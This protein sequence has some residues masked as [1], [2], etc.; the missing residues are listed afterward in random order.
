MFDLGQRKTK[1]LLAVHGWAGI[2]FGIL[3]YAVVLTGTIAV[4]A[5]EIGHWSMGVSEGPSVDHR[6]IDAHVRKAVNSIDPRFRHDVSI[7]PGHGGHL[8]VWAHT[9]EKRPNGQSGDIGVL[10]E[11]DPETGHEIARREGWSTEVFRDAASAL[12]RFLIDV[13]VRLHLPNPWGLLLTGVLGLAMMAA[14]VSGFLMH[15]NLIRDS[16]TL[17]RHKKTL[18][19]ARD[20]HSVAGTWGLAFAFLLALTGAFFS[21]ALSIGLPLMTLVAFGG[22]QAKLRATLVGAP[23]VEDARPAGVADLDAMIRDAKVRVGGSVNRVSI[24]DYGRED[25]KVTIGLDPHPG[26]L[27]PA[28]LVYGAPDGAFVKRKARIG[29]E[30][31]F[32]STLFSTIGPL[33]FGNFGGV[34]SKL[35]W[36]AL[37]FA[38]CFM[39]ATGMSL[40]LRRR[41][42]DVRWRM[43]ACVNATVIFGLPIALAASAF[44]FFLSYPTEAALTTTPLAFLAAAL[45][46][47]VYACFI[48]PRVGAQALE[49]HL[50]LGL[51]VTLLA[52]PIVRIATGG[53]LWTNAFAAGAYEAFVIDLALILGGAFCIRSARQRGLSKAATA[54]DARPIEGSERP[55]MGAAE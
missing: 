47:I 26:T 51:G 14:A 7:F 49:A 44:G 4:F 46:V 37:G 19:A 12:E 18:V 21:F 3:L 17:R 9:H 34:I 8:R 35:V 22:D 27:E 31:S 55:Q 48:S 25:G 5:H 40:W 36:L 41:A 24:T 43:F 50:V 30:P 2:V 53:I 1:I 28:M 15:P 29:T 45:L 23:A 16:F 39:I 54:S 11:I 6:P 10:F 32:G 52:L 20:E 33:H 38:S 13:H 42:A